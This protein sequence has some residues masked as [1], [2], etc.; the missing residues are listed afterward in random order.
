MS[1]PQEKKDHDLFDLDINKYTVADLERFFK[2]NYSIAPYTADEVQYKEYVIREELM[3][4]VQTNKK[5]KSELV[6][7]LE[8]AKRVIIAA[9]C[10]SPPSLTTSIPQNFRLDPTPD[11][12]LPPLSISRNEELVVPTYIKPLHVTTGNQYYNGALNPIETR[13]KTINLCVDTLFRKNYFST[14]STDFTYVLPKVINNVVSLKL[15]SFEFPL[16]WNTISASDKNNVMYVSLYNM[17]VNGEPIPDVVDFEI[18]IPDGNYTQNAFVQ[19]MNNIFTQHG[20]IGLDFLWCEVDSLTSSTVFRARN[21]ES[22]TSLLIGINSSF[23]FYD[24]SSD[25][26]QA[27]QYSPDFYFTVDFSLK[28]DMYLRPNYKNLGW[29]LG[30]RETFYTVTTAKTII[31]YTASL[32]KPLIYEC[33]LKSESI[34]GGSLNSY[35][36]VEVDDFQNNFPTDSIISTN[37]SYGNYLGKNIIARSVISSSSGVIMNDNGADLIFKKRDYF[38]P[39]NLEK[40]KIRVLSRYGDVINTNQTDYSMTFEITTLNMNG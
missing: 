29:L 2:L 15:A 1:Q 14:K 37:D 5:I 8:N 30:F 7:F 10:P 35:F 12:P 17:R 39:V 22:E 20:D 21:Y 13:V 19:T 33:Y 25:P 6:T 18:V 11:Y 28:N 4:S 36:F 40:L 23:P 31:S 32:S 26:T 9:K 34:F 3:K 27:T 16:L 24:N 38:G